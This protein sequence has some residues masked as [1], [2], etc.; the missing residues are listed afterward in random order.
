MEMEKQKS[1]AAG[2]KVSGNIISRGMGEGN[3]CWGRS[4]YVEGAA[5]DWC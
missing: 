5:N 2:R 4:Q 3:L 1:E